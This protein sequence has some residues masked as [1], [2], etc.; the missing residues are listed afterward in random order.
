MRKQ[1]KTIV[2]FQLNV[3][4]KKNGETT[5]KLIILINL[6]AIAIK[7]IFQKM[8]CVKMTFFTKMYIIDKKT[9]MIEIRN[10]N[11]LDKNVINIFGVNLKVLSIIGAEKYSS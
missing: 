9:L 6:G 2:N 10:F 11:N 7:V 3:L 1:K 8:P 5:I 4:D